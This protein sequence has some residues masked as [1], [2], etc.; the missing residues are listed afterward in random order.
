MFWTLRF[1]LYP[2]LLRLLFCGALR[3]KS[4]SDLC[5]TSLVAVAD[6]T[7][8]EGSLLLHVCLG[9]F[10]ERKEAEAENLMCVPVM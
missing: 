7:Y 3:L 8:L 9:S 4:S 6:C 10:I 5:I 1:L 2:S